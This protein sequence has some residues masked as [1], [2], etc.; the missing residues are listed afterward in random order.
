LKIA[1]LGAGNVGRA[2]GQKWVE[3]GHE[4]VFGVRDP[5]S[6][7]TQA[8]LAAVQG[9]AS[10][11][12][13]AN[14][15]A[16]GE[17]VLFAIPNAAVAGTVAAHAGLLN[18]KTIID[19]TNRFSAPEVSHLST[20]MEL[21]PQARIFRAFNS[22]GWEV[23]AAPV[24]DGL[25]ADLLYCGPDDEARPHIEGLIADAGMRAV[26]VG[27]LDQVALVDAVGALWIALAVKQGRGRRLAFKVLQ[28]E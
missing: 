28:D 21:T 20:F 24:F 2:L 7:K 22:I 8:T 10:A 1:I 18:R 17:V 26:R 15:I 16:F 25:A 11:D 27:D 13:I 6:P 9:R 14:A 5:A 23:F 4:V 12:S 19:A 3:A